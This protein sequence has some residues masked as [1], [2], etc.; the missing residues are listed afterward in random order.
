MALLI[1]GPRLLAEALDA[2]VELTEVFIDRPLGSELARRLDAAGVAVVEVVAGLL[3]HVG[4]VVVSQGVLAVARVA[5]P[6]SPGCLAGGLGLVLADVADPG[7]VGSILRTADAVA[8]RGVAL[9]GRSV[10]WTSP[11]VVRASAGAVFRVSIAVAESP[12]QTVSQLQARGVRCVGAVVRGGRA[13]YDIDLTGSVAIVVGNESQ[14]LS[15]GVCDAVDELMHLPM[16]GRAESLNVAMAA[17]V[18]AF[19]S[20]R[21]R[22][23]QPIA[24]VLGTNPRQA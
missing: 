10:D 14:G 12:E 15:K 17:T 5:E 18:L 9:V 6:S 2:S 4:D 22:T 19:E 20:V 1:E 24:L 13:H 23:N 3:D 11:K 21:Q 8:A 16:P 7:N